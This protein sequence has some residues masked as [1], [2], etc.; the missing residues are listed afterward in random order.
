M[1]TSDAVML[2]SCSGLRGGCGGGEGGRLVV[3]LAGDHAVVQAA[4][5]P[6]E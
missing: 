1:E 5:E 4:E 2:S 3:V 6:A